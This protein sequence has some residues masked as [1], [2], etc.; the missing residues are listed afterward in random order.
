MGADFIQSNDNACLP[1]IEFQF[2]FSFANSCCSTVRGLVNLSDIDRRQ[3]P[4]RSDR[5]GRDFPGLR[6]TPLRF[7]DDAGKL[8]IVKILIAE[9]GT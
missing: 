7:A 9:G 2:Q 5:W 4:A 1:L 8:E 3:S 6:W